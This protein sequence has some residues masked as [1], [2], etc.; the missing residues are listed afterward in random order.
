MTPRIRERPAYAPGPRR[1]ASHARRTDP[2][3]RRPVSAALTA[4]GPA[5]AFEARRD[6]RD[7]SNFPFDLPEPADD[8]DRFTVRLPPGQRFAIADIVF[9]H[10]SP[11]AEARFEHLP[12]R[13]DRGEVE[14]AVHWSH[15]PYGRVAYT[16]RVHASADGA[17]PRLTVPESSPGA[18][19]RTKALL[20]Q[21]AEISVEVRGDNAG[22]LKA[23][24][25]ATGRTRS[26]T[27]VQAQEVVTI[28]VIAGVV[29]AAI[30]A[31]CVIIGLLVVYRI[32]SDAMEKGY[33]VEDTKFTGAVGSGEHR[34]QQTMVFN[35]KKRQP[36]APG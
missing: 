17:P 18:D 8:V 7:P 6:H 4:P 10:L 24:L 32:V 26:Q 19:Q 36:S 31:A 1:S 14:V 27:L 16:L 11:L 34:S 12:N 2:V 33:D 25:E 29:I 28:T 3:Q 22:R 20:A 15:A 21:G 35:L 5:P 9:D 23:A 13:G 30:M